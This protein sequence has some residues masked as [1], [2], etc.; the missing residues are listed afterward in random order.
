M[1]TFITLEPGDESYGN[2]ETIVQKLAS[3][4]NTSYMS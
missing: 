4:V 3:N 2:Y 1:K